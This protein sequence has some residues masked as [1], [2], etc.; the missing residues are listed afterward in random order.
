MILRIWNLQNYVNTCTYVLYLRLGHVLCP[1]VILYNVGKQGIN[2]PESWLSVNSSVFACNNQ[3]L[4][5][6]IIL[7]LIR[8]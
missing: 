3:K 8:N 5:H 1:L 4:K 7:K 2:P 6:G